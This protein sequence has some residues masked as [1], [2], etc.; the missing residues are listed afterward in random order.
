MGHIFSVFVETDK[1]VDRNY[2]CGWLISLGSFE[3]ETVHVSHNISPWLM[4]LFGWDFLQNYPGIL[5]EIIYN[6]LNHKL[7]WY[8]VI[9]SHKM[10]SQP[11]RCLVEIDLNKIENMV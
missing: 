5:T 6:F 9:M 7:K 4:V 11:V 10:T 2:S 3:V 1:K 8:S